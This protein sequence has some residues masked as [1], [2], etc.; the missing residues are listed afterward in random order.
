MRTDQGERE[1]ADRKRFTSGIL[2]NGTPA[3][4]RVAAPRSV[5]PLADL[6]RKGIRSGRTGATTSTMRLDQGWGGGG[7]MFLGMGQKPT[8][9]GRCTFDPG[10]LSGGLQA[11]GDRHDSSIDHNKIGQS[12]ILNPQ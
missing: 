11:T 2:P 5:E 6:T 3:T 8:A 10:A 12:C 4:H 9:R 1:M 7:D